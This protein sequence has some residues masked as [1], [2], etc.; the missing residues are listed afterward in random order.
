MSPHL[1]PDILNGLS[2]ITGGMGLVCF[3][4]SLSD[5]KKLLHGLPLAL[6]FWLASGL[7]RLSHNSEWKAIATAAV[8]VIVR[9]IVVQALTPVTRAT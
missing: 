4:A 1:Y 3:V 7:L 9:K 5:F 8:V 6:D 2:L